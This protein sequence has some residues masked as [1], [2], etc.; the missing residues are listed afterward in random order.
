MEMICFIL[1]QHTELDFYTARSLKHLSTSI[2]LHLDTLS[3]L[4]VNQFLLLLLH[5][6]CLAEKFKVFYVICQEIKPTAIEMNTLTKVIN[7]LE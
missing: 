4:L 7:I 2:S 3:R 5:A 6:T 1:Y